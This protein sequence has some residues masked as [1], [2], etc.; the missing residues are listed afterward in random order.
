[1]RKPPPRTSGNLD[2]DSSPRIRQPES[3]ASPPT[4][5]KPTSPKERAIPKPTKAVSSKEAEDAVNHPP[6]HPFQNRRQVRHPGRRT[7]RRPYLPPP[8]KPEKPTAPRLHRIRTQHGQSMPNPNQ[9]VPETPRMANQSRNFDC[10]IPR[11][12]NRQIH[13]RPRPPNDHADDY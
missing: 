9:P 1:M 3:Q 11:E 13:R 7:N 8:R 6:D 2:F 10:R 12:P 5:R 4:N